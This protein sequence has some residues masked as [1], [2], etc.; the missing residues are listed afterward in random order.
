MIDISGGVLGML[1]PPPAGGRQLPENVS[2][3]ADATALRSVLSTAG[4]TPQESTERGQ[5]TP[6]EMNRIADGMTVLVSCWD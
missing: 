2:L 4:L 6:D 3:A 1:L 5:I